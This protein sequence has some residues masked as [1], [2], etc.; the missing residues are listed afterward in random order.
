MTTETR[1]ILE[2]TKEFELIPGQKSLAGEDFC[3][4]SERR[5]SCFIGVGSAPED[6]V[7]KYPLH[8]PIHRISEEALVVGVK[9]W[10]SIIFSD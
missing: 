8:S 7:D 1:S 5:P 3:E 9:I 10:L 2:K 4:F 6:G